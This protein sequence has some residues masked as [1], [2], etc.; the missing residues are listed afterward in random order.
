[1]EEIGLPLAGHRSKSAREYLGKLP[2][3]HLIVVCAETER[4]CPKLFP[5]AVHFYSWPFPDPVAARGSLSAKIESF[6]RVRD[7]IEER[8]IAWLRDPD[9][10]LVGT[11]A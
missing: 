6:R 1:M 7:E 4:E 3:H 2:V 5:G 11:R 9:T 8:V 10:G